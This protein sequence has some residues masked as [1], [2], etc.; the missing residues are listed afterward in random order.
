MGYRC[1]EGATKPLLCSKDEEDCGFPSAEN[2]RR[3]LATTCPSGQYWDGVDTCYACPEGYTCAGGT[4]HPVQCNL[5]EYSAASATLCTVS[6]V[7]FRNKD[8]KKNFC[9]SRQIMSV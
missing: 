6:S 1:K 8:L 3:M 7:F 5:G 9:Y 4:A 2:G